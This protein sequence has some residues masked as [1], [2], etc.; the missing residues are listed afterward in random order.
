[1]LKSIV[2]CLLTERSGNGVTV[3]GEPLY[4]KD[5]AR[6][7]FV[8]IQNPIFASQSTYTILAHLLQH[9]TCLP[10]DDHQLLVRMIKIMP[11]Q[12]DL[13]KSVCLIKMSFNFSFLK[14]HWF[15]TLEKKRFR[16]ILRTLLQ[17]V[18][19][20]QFPPLDKVLNNST[21]QVKQT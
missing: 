13:Q 1:M 15:R 11:E 17:F 21:A 5:Y 2:G 7:L 19:I 16:A 4:D 14:V 12:I 10:N 20:R 9:I 6:T 18:T 8:L 3:S